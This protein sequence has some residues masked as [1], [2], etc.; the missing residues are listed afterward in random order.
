M[1]DQDKMR[2]LAKENRRIYDMYQRIGSEVE[3]RGSKIHADSADAIDALL[4]EVEAANRELELSK[5]RVMG[6]T[7]AVESITK[8]VEQLRAEL[9]AAAADKRD[10]SVYR[11]MRAQ[12]WISIFEEETAIH[13][14]DQKERLQD[15]LA[16]RQ[17]EG[18]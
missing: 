15:A 4:A 18:S 3:K 12:Y 11:W 13:C 1:I 14:M 8:L 10:A 9:E 17:G 5:L 7:A 6:S 16:Q 2:A